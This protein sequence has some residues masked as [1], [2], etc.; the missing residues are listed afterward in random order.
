MRFGVM[1]ALLLL[2][3]GCSRSREHHSSELIVFSTISSQPFHDTIFTIEVDGSYPEP[4]IA[5]KNR[6]SFVHASGN[7]L[8]EGLIVT[9][10]EVDTSGRVANHNV[11]YKPG[12][13]QWER[14]IEQNGMEGAGYLS[15]DGS[16]VVCIFN[17]QSDAAQELH[18]WIIDLRSREAKK[19]TSEESKSGQWD[20]PVSWRSDSQEILF[21]RLERTAEVITT[22]LMQVSMSGGAPTQL[23]GPDVGVMAACYS[24]DGNRMAV[25]TSSGLE[26]IER[27]NLKRQLILPWGNLPHAQ[28][29]SGGLVWSRR[30]DLISF[31]V[32][33]TV[34]KRYELWTVP[35]DGSRPTNI[36]HQDESQ[37]RITVTSFIRI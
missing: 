1:L 35:V 26:L 27:S 31:A 29:R 24:P 5:P 9:V 12:T 34:D 11:W 10:H 30:Q 36:Y 13:A 19:L 8:K 33:N 17:P 25:F 14:V 20:G 6:Q 4:L 28:F 3:P 18:P 32:F 23:L 7:S 2:V 16:R 15:P 22:T 21:V 37:G